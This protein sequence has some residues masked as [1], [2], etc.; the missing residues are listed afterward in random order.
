L[1]ATQS[2]APLRQ[3]AAMDSVGSIAASGMRAAELRLNVAAYNIANVST[4][5]STDAPA[6]AAAAFQ[7]L[8]VDQTTTA[9]GGT[10]ATV[11]AQFPNDALPSVDLAS[12]AIE[13]VTARYTFAAN[14]GVMRSVAQLQKVL[15]DAFA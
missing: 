4:G 8:R 11:R 7:P 10:A 2:N 15:L 12:E 6:D 5:G 9:G 3:N 1:R 14:V 13:V